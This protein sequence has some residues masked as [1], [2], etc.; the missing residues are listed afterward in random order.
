MLARRLDK[1]DR[2]SSGFPEQLDRLL[3]DKQWVKSLELL[4]EGELGEIIGHLNDVK[5]NLPPTEPYLSPL[6][7]R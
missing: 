1:L 6:D 4:A 3:H 2:S 5:L 7:S